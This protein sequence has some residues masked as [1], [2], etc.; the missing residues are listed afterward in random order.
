MYT[1]GFAS[2]VLYGSISCSIIFI[3]LKRSSI[4]DVISLNLGFSSFAD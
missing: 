2:M 1:S 3:S 4:S